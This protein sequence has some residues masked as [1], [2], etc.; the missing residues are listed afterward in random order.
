[1]SQGLAFPV[2]V[3]AGGGAELVSG[4]KQKKK[5]LS[6][7]FSEGNDNNP[8]QDL[9]FSAGIIFQMQGSGLEGDMRR[10]V[11]DILK[12]FDDTIKLSPEDN[13]D[14]I[15]NV[16]GELEMVIRWIDTETQKIEEFRKTFVR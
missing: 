12:T 7:A 3:N 9:G 4:S 13:I 5:L 8:F 15:R 14:F 6:L 2:R 10:R 11:N 1:M 16:E